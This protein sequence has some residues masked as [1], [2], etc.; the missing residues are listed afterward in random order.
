MPGRCLVTNYIKGL[1]GGY[2]GW[3]YIG[4]M[5]NKMDTTIWGLGS[6]VYLQGHGDA[7]SRLRMGM[8]GVIIWLCPHDPSSCDVCR[9]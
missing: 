8:N 4:I 5:E 1:Y 7:V 2:I 6:R 3:G 9:T